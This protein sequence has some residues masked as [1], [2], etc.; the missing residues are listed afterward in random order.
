[1]Q[2]FYGKSGTGKT[3]MAKKLF[4]E[5]NIDYFVAGSS[6]DPL[7]NYAGQEALILD[8]LREDTFSYADLLKILDPYNY[9]KVG[10][11]RYSDKTLIV[12]TIIVTTPYSLKEFYNNVRR[13]NRPLNQKVDTFLQLAR[14]LSLLLKFKEDS[15]VFE[16]YDSKLDNYFEEKSSRTDNMFNLKDNSKQSKLIEEREF[17]NFMKIKEQIERNVN[18]NEQ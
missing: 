6:K 16:T 17:L 5:Q 4:D 14:R 8:E 15:L 12:H 1:M 9:E 18:E 13:G 11:S 3:R 10:A 2:W 7:Q